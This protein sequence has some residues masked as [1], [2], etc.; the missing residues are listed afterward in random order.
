MWFIPLSLFRWSLS[1]FACSETCPTPSSELNERDWAVFIQAAQFEIDKPEEF[2]SETTPGNGEHTWRIDWTS[3]DLVGTDPSGEVTVT[4]DGQPFEGKGFWSNQECGNFSITFAGKYLSPD[5][6]TE[7]AF[8]ASAL[9]AVFTDEVGN[10]TESKL[11]G[12]LD[13]EET[14][15]TPAGIVGTYT[16]QAQVFGTLQ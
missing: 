7:H 16:A 15:E 6:L 3:P 13:W 2:P 4:V 1:L 12:F 11:E 9:L 8:A 14:W 10:E 5:A